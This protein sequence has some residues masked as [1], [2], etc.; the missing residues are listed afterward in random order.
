MH[1]PQIFFQNCTAKVASGEVEREKRAG[2]FFEEAEESQCISVNQTCR[3][4]GHS[5]HRLR[6]RLQ[7]AC[8]ELRDEG[9]CLK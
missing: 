4:I 8:S 7:I 9:P 2:R 6:V 1:V 5:L 3:K